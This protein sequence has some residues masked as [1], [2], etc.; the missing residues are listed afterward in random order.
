[1]AAWNMGVPPEAREALATLR[2]VMLM[3]RDIG[4]RVPK[5][6]HGVH[7]VV[8]LVHGFM[9]SAGVFRPLKKQLERD[10]G[11]HVASFSHVPGAS[12]PN[13]AFDLGNIVAKLPKDARVHIVGHSLGG[14][15]ARYYV[16][17]LGG[18]TRVTQTIALAAPFGG[19]PIASRIPV[20]V[21]RDL[22]P[23]SQLLERIRARAA[24]HGVPHLSIAGTHDRTVPHALAHA[25]P[26]GERVSLHGR[27]HN[28]LLFDEEVT[29]LV[30]ERVRYFSRPDVSSSS[31]PPR[32][33]T[34]RDR[35]A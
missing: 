5:A 30:V 1:M 4:E 12:V 14:V 33:E 8:V 3:P 10:E 7:D 27:G 6:K 22:H 28:T 11:T 19:A 32:A 29:R 9:A 31:S 23:K 35:R 15:V 24:E 18:H 13:I 17:E 25:L 16:Q 2:E 34:A 20:F 21:G 26:H